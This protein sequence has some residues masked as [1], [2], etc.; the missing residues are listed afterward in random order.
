[1]SGAARGTSLLRLLV[2][3]LGGLVLV[4]V[5]HQVLTAAANGGDA[6]ATTAA[7]VSAPAPGTPATGSGLADPDDP[8]ADVFGPVALVRVTVTDTGATE[9]V[10]VTAAWLDA[11]GIEA[12]MPAGPGDCFRLAGSIGGNAYTYEYICPQDAALV[13]LAA[14]RLAGEH[15]DWT[16]TPDLTWESRIYLRVPLADADARARQTQDAVA[17]VTGW[18]SDIDS[19]G[20]GD[21]FR[22]FGMRGPAITAEQARQAADAVAA[23]N[24]LESG[25][26]TVSPSPTGAS[27]APRPT[28]VIDPTE[29]VDPTGAAEPGGATE[30]TG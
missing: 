16:V 9:G 13:L 27:G 28:E 19:V 15:P 8:P 29:A 20:A 18:T 14:D 24:G 30:P 12:G 17:G 25:Q 5:G 7:P 11:L 23:A 6:T 2:L 26:V 21:G 3:S 1:M 4:G 10:D 22:E